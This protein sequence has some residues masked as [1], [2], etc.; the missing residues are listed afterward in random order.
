MLLN[1][2]A[3]G[4]CHD[5]AHAAWPRRA[6]SLDRRKGTRR[7][8]GAAPDSQWT[9][10]EVSGEVQHPREAG[11][12]GERTPNSR[13]PGVRHQVGLQSMLEGGQGK[14]DKV[15]GVPGKA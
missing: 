8:D 9:R 12:L 4:L 11:R 10:G 1:W 14:R 6:A 3:V 13:T 5:V 2:E 7:G 15:D